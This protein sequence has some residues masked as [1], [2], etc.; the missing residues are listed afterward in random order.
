MLTI[1]TIFLILLTLALGWIR[2]KTPKYYKTYYLC[3]KCNCIRTYEVPNDL[4]IKSVSK[5]YIEL[6]QRLASR[7][8]NS[9]GTKRILYELSE[10][11]WTIQNFLQKDKLKVDLTIHE[12]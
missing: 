1:T 4:D 3:H 9:A 11:M 12:N 7:D 6:L 8:K 2:N 5:E 10:Q